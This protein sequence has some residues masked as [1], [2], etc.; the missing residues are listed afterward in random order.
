MVNGSGEHKGTRRLAKERCR[1]A[2]MH[3][4][5]RC[6]D[7]PREGGVLGCQ[8]V[9]R[10]RRAALVQRLDLSRRR[11]GPLILLRQRG[12]Q[13]RAAVGRRALAQASTSLVSM[14]DSQAT[15]RLA[16]QLLLLALARLL[17]L[18]A[19]APWQCCSERCRRLRAA[20]TACRAPM[21]MATLLTTV[22][23]HLFR[24]GQPRLLQRPQHK[25]QSLGWTLRCSIRARRTMAAPARCKDHDPDLL[26]ACDQGS[27]DL[28]G[29][30][31][32][33]VC[34][35]VAMG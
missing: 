19:G 31:R 13:L 8:Q 9:A 14:R 17:G 34:S 2:A 15:H 23:L 21:Q 35:Q 33:C 7:A 4:S 25:E 10:R 22:R 27:F 12:V 30:N 28:K 11:R 20:A 1:Q 16:S 5:A 32:G 3:S 26:H 18:R 29:S 24:T 6:T